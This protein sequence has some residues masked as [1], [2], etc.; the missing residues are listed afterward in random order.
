MKRQKHIHFLVCLIIVF[1][2]G[3]LLSCSKD[4]N[5]AGYLS[6]EFRLDFATVNIEN[7]A[8]ILSLDNKD[9]LRSAISTFNFTKKE[10]Q[11]VVV[12]HSPDV[13]NSISDIFTSQIFTAKLDTLQAEPVKVQSVWIGGGYLNMILYINYYSKTHR[14]GLY[15]ANGAPNILQLCHDK[16]GDSEGYPVKVYLSFL[17]NGLQ[18]SSD[19][20]VSFSVKIPISGGFKQYDFSF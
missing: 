3:I 5:D 19:G 10:G 16:Q 6:G 8:P 1:I 12:N 4:D 13:V 2:S 9:T 17:M 11:R 14:L 18:K 15:R 20:I 7:N